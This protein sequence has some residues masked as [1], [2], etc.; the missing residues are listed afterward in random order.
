MEY[1]LSALLLHKV[2]KE[3]NEENITSV[4]KATGVDVVD[5][6]VKALVASIGDVD[7]EKAIEEAAA[8]PA[9]AA[10]AAAGGDD[11]AKEDDSA[12]KEEKSE[13]DKKQ[14]EEKAAAG[15]GSLFG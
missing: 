7:I 15:L 14:E 5:A 9:A 6:K 8:A 4:L 1:V 12:K 2:G 10:P 13:E 11:K 3:I